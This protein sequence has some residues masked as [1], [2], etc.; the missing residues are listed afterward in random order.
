MM[1][2]ITVTPACPRA[3]VLLSRQMITSSRIAAVPRPEQ[4]C[5]SFEGPDRRSAILAMIGAGALALT[6]ASPSSS[7]AAEEGVIAGVAPTVAAAAAAATYEH[8]SE[9]TLAYEFDYPAVTSSGRKIP[10]VFSRRPERYSSAAP[11]TADARQRIVCE[12]ADLIDA[13]TVS[14]SVGPPAGSLR[15][16]PQSQ[17]TA[18]QVAAE[19]L[20]DRSTARVTSGQRVSLNTIEEANSVEKDGTIYYIYEHI[21]Q[22]SPTLATTSRET[23]RHSLAVTAARP[24]LEEGSLFLYT[25]NMACPEEKWTELESAYRHGVGSFTLVANPGTDYVAPDQDSWSV[26]DYADKVSALDRLQH[27]AL[28]EVRTVVWNTKYRSDICGLE[29]SGEESYNISKMPFS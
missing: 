23:Y 13:I 25:L 21:S 6:V 15:T 19:I 9:P 22:G 26:I 1:Q 4:S 20:A 29:R 28:T 17:W 3:S 7:W 11:L 5:T 8:L 10:L 27:R 18:K 16:T 14:V 12:L 2:F 24:G